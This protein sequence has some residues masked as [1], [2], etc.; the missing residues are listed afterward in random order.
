MVI[1]KKLL[2]LIM[3]MFSMSLLYGCNKDSF[4]FGNLGERYLFFEHYFFEPSLGQQYS[5]NNGSIEIQ[6]FDLHDR[7]D[8]YTFIIETPFFYNQLLQ[9]VDTHF[10]SFDGNL[11]KQPNFLIL[12]DS[13]DSVIMLIYVLKSYTI[14]EVSRSFSINISEVQLIITRTAGVFNVE[15]QVF[16]TVNFG[17]SVPSIN[18][19]LR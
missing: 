10:L 3:L 4:Q 1:M 14:C 15:Y 7:T 6:L 19:I 13:Q 9:H 5:R 12:F 16:R 11:Y 17:N 18:Y 2:I 8:T